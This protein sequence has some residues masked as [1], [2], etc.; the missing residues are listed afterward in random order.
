MSFLQEVKNYTLSLSVIDPNTGERMLICNSIWKTGFR[1]FVVDIIS[2]TEMYSEL[3]EQNKWMAVLPTYRLSQDHLEMFFGKIRSMNGSNDNPTA[4]QF[5]SAYRKLLFN[6]DIQ[7]SKY[8]NVR[9]IVSSN[10]L[11]IPSFTQRSTLEKDVVEH[12][13]LCVSVATSL[14][15]E[16]ELTEEW[17][18]ALEW[19]QISQS[20]YLTG[21]IIDCGIAFVANIIEKRLRC[22]KPLVRCDECQ[23]VLDQNEKIDDETC[24]SVINGKPCLST[25]QICKLTDMAIQIYINS[26]DKMKQR[27]YLEVMNNICFGNLFKI[28][29]E[30]DHDIEH[31]HFMVKFII[32]IY[33]TNKKCAYIAKQHTLDLQKN[34]YA[35]SYANNI[36]SH[37][38]DVI[39]IIKSEESTLYSVHYGDYSN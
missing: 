4:L 3:I 13:G 1:G 16:Q 5:L 8:S 12:S 18:E 2:L 21:G 37:I 11:T 17:Q 9:A 34:T 28:F 33:N 30:P 27:I 29:Y 10:I 24:V 25:Y 26:G 32:L 19:E 31:K 39:S 38:N 14:S 15:P 23:R 22:C 20:D 36:T 7:V 6:A 35:T